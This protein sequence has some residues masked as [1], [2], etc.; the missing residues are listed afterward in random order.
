MLADGDMIGVTSRFVRDPWDMTPL[1]LPTLK[2]RDCTLRP[3]TLRDASALREACG[4]EDICRF[5]TVPRAYS[6]DAAVQ[7]IGRQHAHASAGTAIVL[8]IIPT[9]DQEPVGMIGLFGL[10]RP[11]AIARF[12]YW[13]LARARGRGLAKDAAQALGEWAFACLGIEALVI[14]CEPTNQA[15]VRVAAHLGRAHRLA[16]GPRRR[17]GG[18]T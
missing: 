2:T 14:D 7:W 12:G 18:R 17:R 8:A 16:M 11:E 4:D 6:E 1:E 5:T 3:W 15:S 10:D 13:L 9:G